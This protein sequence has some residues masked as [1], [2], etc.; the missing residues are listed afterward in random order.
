[1][2]YSFDWKDLVAAFVIFVVSYWFA[3]KSGA[4][5]LIVN[6]LDKA[7]TDKRKKVRGDITGEVNE[8]IDIDSYI[9]KVK[10]NESLYL[11][12]FIIGLV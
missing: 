4:S 1:M 5:R 3:F 7:K 10:E 8:E 6:Y 2:T 11:I 12:V 9:K